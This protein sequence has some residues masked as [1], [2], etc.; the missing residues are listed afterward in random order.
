[1][2]F[3]AELTRHFIKTMPAQDQVHS[4]DNRK[5]DM[6]LSKQSTPEK[7]NPTIET[8]SH[9]AMV[10]TMDGVRC[11]RPDSPCSNGGPQNDHS[12]RHHNMRS[13][14]ESASDHSPPEL[15]CLN[16]NEMVPRSDADSFN[17]DIS[18]LPFPP[19]PDEVLLPLPPDG[20]WGWVIVVASF[21][22]CAVIDGLCSVF[23][24]LLPDLVV[25]FEESSS[26]VSLAGSVLAGGFLLSGM[27]YSLT[28]LL[29]LLEMSIILYC[30]KTA[31]AF[32]AEAEIIIYIT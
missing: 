14:S 2:L 3:T 18:D 7:K 23:G 22:C 17:D 9:G 27:F 19:F 11:S 13:I 16:E 15:T 8:P 21:V 24:V 30:M 20:G 1:M 32:T 10:E 4:A 12:R 6:E 25:Y 26:K 28:L 5:S 31:I 29:L